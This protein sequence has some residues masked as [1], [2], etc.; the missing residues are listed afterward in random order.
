MS[1]VFFAIITVIS[2]SSCQQEKYTGLAAYPDMR[3][4]FTEAEMQDL[5][6][7]LAFFEHEI[8]DLLQV[9]GDSVLPCYQAF[10][11]NV[12]HAQSTGVLYV[13]VP[14][15][16]QLELYEKLSDAAFTQI[17]LRGTGVD[18]ATGDTV[19]RM[20]LSFDGKY[21]RFLDTLKIDHQIIDA[22][23]RSFKD[24]H[25]MSS[26]MIEGV[27]YTAHLYDLSDL[28]MRLFIAMHYLTVN[29]MY[30]RKNL[31]QM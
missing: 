31:E 21:M 23:T 13:A 2:I 15:D 17:W 10:I 30:E 11:A 3:A 26:K 12:D 22:Y 20:N 5:E 4:I 9:P 1:S 24:E 25:R 16:K 14:F 7:I 6:T 18:Q 29:D 28:R 8:C 27:L 19:Q